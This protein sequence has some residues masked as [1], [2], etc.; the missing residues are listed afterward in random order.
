MAPPAEE[1]P[2]AAGAPP[3]EEAT[4]ARLLV[5]ALR[6]A[7]VRYAFANL[8]SDH[9][10]LIEALAED[11]ERGED[12]PRVVLCPHEATALGAAHGYSAATGEPTAVLV[13]TDVGTANLGGMVHNAHRS[14]VPV[15]VFAGLTPY[16]L[17][18][19]LPGSRTTHVNHLQDVPDQHALVRQYVKWSYDLRTARNVPQ[20]VRRGLQ[21]A[22]SA[23][24]G[25]VYLTAAREVLAETAPRPDT[26]AHGDW[27]PLAPCPAPPGTV[28]ALAEAVDAARSAVVV[29]SYAGR[30]RDAV[31]ALAEAAERLGLAVVEPYAEHVSLPADHPLHAGDDPRPLVAE[32]DVI[33]ALQTDAPWLHTAVSP[34]PGATVAVV[35]EDPLQESIPLWYYP[36]THVVRADA[37][38]FLRQLLAAAAA[39]HSGRGPDPDRRAERVEAAER[40]HGQTRE[41]WRRQLREDRSGERLTAATVAGAL[42]ELL[43]PEAVV[44][45]EAITEAPAVW[46]HLPRTRAGT[47]FGNRGT[48]LGWFG[49]GALG[50]R[51]AA[52]DRPV[53]AVV[54]DGTYLLGEPASAAWVAG[55][56]GLPTLTVV[57]DNGGWRATQRNLVR[58]H[59]GGVADAT[60]RAF[61]NLGQ[62]ADLPGIASA[63]GGAW[64]ATVARHADLEPALRRGLEAV[65]GGRAAVVAVRLPPISRQAPDALR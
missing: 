37:A 54:G 29:T 50:V 65:A 9:P 61:V 4:A 19:E 53:V 40:L 7:G 16:T 44:I 24:R 27:P 46:R 13:H 63:A 60:D 39:L 33:I 21:L 30:D 55:R 36:A 8:G 62:T 52:G 11:R 26:T 18:G 56:Y 25:P 38:T 59:P 6:E 64:G 22:L 1:D 43:P 34:R 42:A 12:A 2:P 23:P 41:E 47:L 5:E 32:A 57:L 35:N 48:S 45:N 10:A 20:V 14:R 49:G 17:E 28:E 58:Q 31:G 3:A 15:L 51:L